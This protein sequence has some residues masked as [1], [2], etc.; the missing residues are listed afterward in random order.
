MIL[1]ISRVMRMFKPNSPESSNNRRTAYN[2]A[3]G[4]TT[5]EAYKRQKAL[6]DAGYDITYDGYWGDASNQAW[7]EY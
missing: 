3:R 7:N 2:Q 4:I 5:A 1:A 6:R